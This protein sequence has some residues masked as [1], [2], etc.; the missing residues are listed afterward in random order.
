[1]KISIEKNWLFLSHFLSV[2]SPFL[3]QSGYDATLKLHCTPCVLVLAP[4]EPPPPSCKYLRAHHIHLKLCSP[5]Y[6][7]TPPHFRGD[8]K[9]IN[10]TSGCR[11]AAL[12]Q[13]VPQSRAPEELR[14]T[15]RAPS[16]RAS[17][18]RAGAFWKSAAILCVSHSRA[19][20]RV[21]GR[22]VRSPL[23]HGSQH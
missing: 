17:S 6:V 16:G 18:F 10:P 19:A 20:A 2:F 22:A 12:L 21:P 5:I 1:M 11:Q 15:R 23:A 14:C 3:V 8:S 13:A 9:R 4:P 7:S